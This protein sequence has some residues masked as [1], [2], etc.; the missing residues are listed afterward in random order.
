MLI[1]PCVYFL[2]F[3]PSDFSCTL[4]FDLQTLSSSSSNALPCST[5]K[6]PA[7]RAETQQFSSLEISTPCGCKGHL[8][9]HLSKGIFREQLAG[10]FPFPFMPRAFLADLLITSPWES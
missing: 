4:S 10:L 8:W 2:T 7:Q 6:V 9:V 1:C 5:F 3:F